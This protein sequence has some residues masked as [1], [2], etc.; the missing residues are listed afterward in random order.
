RTD[1]RVET[2]LSDAVGKSPR[3]TREQALARAGWP[4]S[5]NRAHVANPAR[6]GCSGPLGAALAGAVRVAIGRQ[7]SGG[8][9]LDRSEHGPAYPSN[10]KA[11]WDARGPGAQRLGRYD[12][13]AGPND[14]TNGNGRPS[15]AVTL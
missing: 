6:H 15:G 5:G 8:V 11:A 14:A 13:T 10:A 9:S 12:G 3:H 7:W 4:G 2:E 1:L